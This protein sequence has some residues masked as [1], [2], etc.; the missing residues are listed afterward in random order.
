MRETIERERESGEIERESE[1]ESEGAHSANVFI[2]SPSRSDSNFELAHYKAPIG[3][4]RI[5]L[6]SCSM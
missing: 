1:R 5:P 6:I 4:R 3:C 2:M